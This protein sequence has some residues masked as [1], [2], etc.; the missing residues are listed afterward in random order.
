MQSY[1]EVEGFEYWNIE[2]WRGFIKGHILPLHNL[3]SRLLK[4]RGFILMI[5]GTSGKTTL[6][7]VERKRS[8][9]LPF[10]LGGIKE[11]GEYKDNSLSKLVRLTL[12]IY[13]NPKEWITLEREEEL[14]A[15]DYVNVRTEDTQFLEFLKKLNDAALKIIKLVELEPLEV[16]EKDIEEIIEKPEKLLEIIRSIYVKCLQVSANHNYYTF[17]S[18]STKTLP[19][20]YMITAYPKLQ[21]NF[22]LFKKFFGLVKVFEPIISEPKVREEY[23][24]YGHLKDGLCYSLYDLNTAIWDNIS[25]EVVKS[26]FSYISASPSDLKQ[27]YAQKVQQQLEEIKWKFPAYVEMSY[28][29]YSRHVYTI[30][31]PILSKHRLDEYTTGDHPWS[32]SRSYYQTVR[33][34][35]LSESRECSISLL[36]LLDELAP[37]LLLSIHSFELKISNG[38]LEIVRG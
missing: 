17:F 36:K 9:I 29:G 32:S 1:D 33:P 25:S 15:F 35:W 8:D 5:V 7:E 11:D 28:G 2:A 14:R 19:F 20:K 30:T 27:E 3:T 6:S 31:G 26:V 24:I 10:L 4:L 22:E 13:V 34:R 16:A 23:T 21:D 38:E 37:A 18:L 12:G